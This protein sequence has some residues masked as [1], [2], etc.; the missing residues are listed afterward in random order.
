MKKIIVFCFVMCFPF[1][2]ILAQTTVA[3]LAVP[4]SINKMDAKGKR[5]GYWE[6]KLENS[7]T[8]KGIYVNGLQNGQW[9]TYGQNGI[10]AKVENYVKGK[11]NGAV[12]EI[13]S[14]GYLS[15]EL[16]FTNDIPE[17]TA[18]RYF[19]GTNLASVIPY[20][21]GKVDGK[22]IIYYENSAGKPMEESN[23]KNDV[24]DG[25]SKWY[26]IAGDVVAEYNYT[27]GN[28]EG[29]QKEFYPKAVLK[30]E[31]NYVKNLPEGE[32][33]E[34]FD[35]A[36]P[37]APAGDVKATKEVKPAEVQVIIGKLKILGNYVKGE[38]DGKWTEFDETGA[39][40]KVSKFVNGIE[41]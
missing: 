1:A 40:V 9:L 35:I 18:K 24:K 13:D 37:E 4:D 2:A 33:K 5:I 6:E 36:K 38:K 20:K 22:K 7:A 15:A 30:S 28:L 31:Q 39:V 27:N 29:I 21:H 23:F 17:G 32:Y 11:K 26:T 10:I 41:K 8:T 12:I 34:Y 19:Y 16:Y 14:R 25:I 3:Q